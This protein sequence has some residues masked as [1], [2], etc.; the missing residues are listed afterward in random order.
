M[1]S[2]MFDIKTNIS[3]AVET[4]SIWLDDLC[5]VKEETDSCIH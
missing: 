3:L 5:Y 4:A 1:W 2:L